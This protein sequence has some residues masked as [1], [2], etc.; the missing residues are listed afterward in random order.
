MST[1]ARDME[2]RLVNGLVLTVKMDESAGGVWERVAALEAKLREQGDA[3]AAMQRDLADM[4]RAMA[5]LKG[6]AATGALG[7]RVRGNGQETGATQG[8]QR[9][10]LAR[11]L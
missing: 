9:R 11:N 1:A 3:M 2:V 7:R 10:A 6:M 5:L 4:R 8:R